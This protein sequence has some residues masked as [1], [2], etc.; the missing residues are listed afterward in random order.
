MPPS[1]EK[2][3]KRG[4]TRPSRVS[5]RPLVTAD[6]QPCE[7]CSGTR[8]GAWRAVLGRCLI[9]SERPFA[10]VLWYGQ[11]VR[12]T[13]FHPESPCRITVPA[14]CVAN[15]SGPLLCAKP[16]STEMRV[17]RRLLPEISWHRGIAYVSTHHL[18]RL[19]VSRPLS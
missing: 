5:W 14:S 13:H 2:S 16:L 1:T 19:C 8:S 6:M 18:R 7:P 11:P 17:W 15:H 10:A 4:L 9:P 12:A 3:F